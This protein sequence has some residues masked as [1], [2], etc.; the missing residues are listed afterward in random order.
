MSVTIK[1][2]EPHIYQATW[3]GTIDLEALNKSSLEI[4]ELADKQ[5]YD[6]YS[7]IVDM[8]D[9]K[10]FPLSISG[11]ADVA[12]IDERITAYICIKSDKIAQYIGKMLNKL[13][14]RD[15]I[16]VDTQQEALEEARKAQNNISTT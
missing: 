13:S 8:T 7:V 11:L 4:S 16:F 3:H 10:K 12:R 15:F 5:Q 14:K 2:V 9:V 6:S 1:H